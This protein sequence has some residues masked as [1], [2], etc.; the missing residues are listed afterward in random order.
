VGTIPAEPQSNGCVYR[1]W[2]TSGKGKGPE[3]V[4]ALPAGSLQSGKR[5]VR[6][7]ILAVRFLSPAGRLRIA[8]GASPWTARSLIRSPSGAN[9]TFNRPAG[10]LCLETGVPRACAAWLIANVPTGLRRPPATTSKL[11]GKILAHQTHL[12]IAR[13]PRRAPRPTHRKQRGAQ[14]PPIGHSANPGWSNAAKRI[15]QA[16][17]PVRSIQVR[18]R[19]R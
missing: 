3:R 6:G 1:L 18:S 19:M 15:R 2:A 10:A 17:T 12:R 5:S 14:N 11:P 9:E 8:T 4:Q 7:N 13:G 16:A